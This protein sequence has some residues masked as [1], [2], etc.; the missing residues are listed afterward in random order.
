MQVRILSSHALTNAVFSSP[1]LCNGGGYGPL[2]HNGMKMQVRILS[3]VLTK[4]ISMEIN[5]DDYVKL[6]N[7][8]VLLVT[9][10]PLDPEENIIVGTTGN[11]LVV[12]DI[13]EVAEVL[14]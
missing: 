7:G 9:D 14:K 2:V 1:C 12:T 3:G 4:G 13:C 11:R 6:R 10:I 8:W 5:L